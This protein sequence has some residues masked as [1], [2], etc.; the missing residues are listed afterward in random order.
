MGFRG[1]VLGEGGGVTTNLDEHVA[2]NQKEAGALAL[3]AGLD[4]GISYEDGYMGG[5]IENVNEG[6]I[7]MSLIDRAVVRILRQKFAL[8][9][10]DKTQVDPDRAVKIVHADAH[11][12]L[13]LRAARES[14]VLLKNNSVLP[15]AKNLKTIAVIGPNADS[16]RNQLGDYIAHNVLQPVVTVR[17]G[18]TRAVA[19]GTRVLYEKG[20]EVRGTDRSGFARAVA[21]AK[22]ADAVVVVVGENERRSPQGGTNGEGFDVSNLDLSGVQE[23]LIQ[24]VAAAGKPTV[25]VLINGRPLSTRWSAENVP[26]LVE[27]WLPGELGGQAVAEVL[28]GDHNPSGHL[29]MTIP[30]HVGQYPFYYNQKPT[31]AYWRD[32][33]LQY[34]NYVDLNGGPLYPFGHGLSYTTFEYSNLRIEPASIGPAGNVR[35]SVDVKNAGTRPGDEVVQLYLNDVVSSVTRPFEELKGFR[36][37]ALRPGETKT[38]EFKL[39]FDEL[40]MLNLDLHPVVEPGEFRVMVGRSS[41]DIRVNGSFRVAQ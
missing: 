13:A 6:R 8:G 39:G 5:M 38:V 24:A 35:V 12:Q 17:E 14:I 11:R 26:A 41:Q 22:V 23:E 30:R 27:A 10:F 25:V 28:F 29:S 3:R 18:V 4:V 31:R 16:P 1:L 37:I 36:K 21:A 7:Q 19:P 40:S 20:C 15:L 2:A 34:R 33:R 9:L 32:G